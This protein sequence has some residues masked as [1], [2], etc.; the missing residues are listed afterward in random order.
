MMIEYSKMIFQEML[1]PYILTFS[2]IIT[3]LNAV[4]IP[5]IIIT[6]FN[7]VVFAVK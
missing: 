6:V 7:R 3:L 1:N 4:V 5:T 2:Q